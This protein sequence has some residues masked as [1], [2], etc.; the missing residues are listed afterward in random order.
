MT[1]SENYL[2]KIIDSYENEA[3]GYDWVG[4]TYCNRINEYEKAVNY[5]TKALEED[6]SYADAFNG[7]GWSYYYLDDNGK[8][9]EFFTKQIELSQQ[10][11]QGYDDRGYVN[12]QIGEYAQAIADLEKAIR[13]DKDAYGY[14][15]NYDRL[16][17]S[18]YKLGDK[19][20]AETYLQ[21]IIDGF[22]NKAE[23]YGWV[24]WTYYQR[25]ENY[26]LAINSFQTAMDLDPQY[27]DGPDGLG[28]S[29]YQKG[30]YKEAI[31]YLLLS[32]D[33]DP[34]NL[35]TT[36][37]WLG[38]SYLQLDEYQNAIIYLTKLSEIAPNDPRAYQGLGD[39]FYKLEDKG[40][41]LAAYHKYIEIMG[42]NG[43]AYVL[44]RVSELESKY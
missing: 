12:Y 8:A 32:L 41:A 40:Q 10:E 24:G 42:E 16:A 9:I 17:V 31:K 36:F 13:L 30:N 28:S 2:Q 14:R 23:G 38:L 34:D 20:R 35:E 29:Y 21:K 27:K 6:P 22:D 4:W 5:F 3:D 11:G 39:V 15:W 43:D 18:Y 25:I 33:A 44:E 1:N 37:A 7:L 26:D 19:V